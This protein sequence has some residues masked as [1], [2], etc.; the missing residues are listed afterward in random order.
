M[1]S[2]LV[3]ELVETL[4]GSG[5]PVPDDIPAA[6]S[7]LARARGLLLGPA[8]LADLARQ[9]ADELVGAGPLQRWLDDPAVT[10][11]LVNGPQ[12]VWV[13]AAGRLVRVQA[14]LGSPAGVRALAVRL[15]ALG[16]RRLDDASPAVDARLPD[17]TRLHAVLP[18]LAGACTLISLRVVRPRAFSL[19]ELVE[20]GTVPGAWVPLLEHLVLSRANLLVSGAT[21]SGKTTLLAALL[22]RVPH[23]ERVLVVEESAELAIDHPHVLRLTTREANVDG[24]GRVDLRELLRHSLRMRPDRIVLGECRG[25]EVRDVLAALGT[26]HAGGCATVHANA[27][28]DVPVR[29]EALALAAGLPRAAIGAQL[30]TAFDVVLHLRRDGPLRRLSE[31]GV[32]SRAADGSGRVLVALTALGDR[33]ARGDGWE[34]LASRWPGAWLEGMA[35]PGRS[36]LTAVGGGPAGHPEHRR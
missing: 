30:C 4:R 13:E 29:I 11:V 26:G 10:D 16:G 2:D 12:D 7:E 9:V 25:A 15:A 17:G 36:R 24:A 28:A 8:P 27:A 32:V 20:A 18:P 1:V 35:G 5:D 19:P 33:Q 21:G 6:V 14:D 34:Q 22:S 31:V 3:A 23:D